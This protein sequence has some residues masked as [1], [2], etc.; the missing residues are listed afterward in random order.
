MAAQNSLISQVRTNLEQYGYSNGRL[1]TDWVYE[2]GIG[3]HT[4]ALAGFSRSRPV[5]DLRTSCI[6]VIRCDELL[7]VTNDSVNKFRGCGAPVVF[8]PWQ[9]NL[10]WWTI[11]KFGAEHRKTILG[12]EIG[13]FFVEHKTEFA[14]ETISRG[15]N[16]A[17]QLVSSKESQLT[18]HDVG[19]MLL[20][21]DMGE[22][23]GKLM[24]RV[25]SLLHNGFTD[26]QLKIPKNQ[27]WTFIAG[28]WLL[29]AKILQD[30]GVKNFV[31]LNLNDV[32][33]VLEAV[34][35]HYRAQQQ[36]QI[37]NKRQRNAIEKAAAE[38]DK[39]AILSNLTTEAF[40]Y[41]YENELVNENLRSAQGIHATPSYLVDYIVWQLWPWIRQIPEEERIVLEPACGHA[42]FLTGAMRLL[43]ELFKGDEKDFHGYAQK[44]LLGIEKDPF[45]REIARLSLTLA[46][47]PNPN[48]W[49]ITEGDIYLGDTL[50]KKAKN[51]TIL[52]CN[53][54]FED[55]T[56]EEQ[57]TYKEA[58]QK[59]NCFN[60]AAEMLWRTLPYM[61]EESVFGVILPRVF[62]HKENLA[63]L[64][65]MIVSDFEL[66]QICLL[67]EN[68]FT[69]AKHRSVVLLGRKTAIGK[70]QN[71][72]LL[73][74]TVE[75]SQR[76]AFKENYK[77]RDTQVFQSKFTESPIF[78]LR[79]RELDDV[80]SYCEANF[81][82][83]TSIAEV[84]RGIEF[85][86]VEK[87]TSRIKFEDAKQGFVKFQKTIPG[88][89]GQRK[90]AD[91]KIT[92]LPDLYWMD[93]SGKAIAN[94]RY[95]MPTGQCRILLNYARISN[96]PWR[97]EA[98]IDKKGRAISN[99]FLAVRTKSV[100]WDI[101]IIF[102]ILNS[103]LSNAFVY[104]NSM[105]RDNL[106]STIRNIPIPKY[107]QEKFANVIK[108]IND[109]F[110]LYEEEHRILHA[111]IDA[112]QV[113]KISLSIDAEILSL[114]DLP[115]KMEKRIL[116][117]FQGV[118]RKGVDFNFKGYYPE[119]FESA[120]PLHE[121]LSEEY[122]RSTVDFVEKW[123][124]ENRSPELIK[125]LE[126][127]VEAFKEE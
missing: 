100:E 87:S 57:R 59:L 106:E 18:F 69:F 54:P 104:C 110:E 23:L 34:K 93:L 111:E 76:D 12:E 1:R 50:S 119:G 75:A 62:L 97:L 55:F 70:K 66:S 39:F 16:L 15:K 45:A 46:D 105:E 115:P 13:D 20:E 99:R 108:L 10:Q 19:L 117:L 114:Y 14:P 49:N 47:V 80:W 21:H 43:R 27:Q 2:D 24:G 28:F 72:R 127:A 124:E 90:K 65:K 61:Q 8:V 7:E 64:R 125:A 77:G 92:E 31:E 3:K 81:P 109:Y 123:V 95:G 60:K 35:I 101:R 56:P 96:T 33:S 40:A 118:P 22:H 5:H 52:L 53:P 63:E 41:M 71:I 107:N 58:G 120:I 42:P 11:G 122:Q 121:Y 29:C 78:D 88:P 98:L 82:T 113:R 9:G 126:K 79:V 94:Q 67:P 116:G 91:I 84:G 17:Y 30:K 37:E 4:V 102:A 44:H 48:G 103:P 25:I 73:Y 32:D 89:K 74:R 36:L 83:I 86:D 85:K 68:I 51:A 112:E 26:E 6:S 38:I